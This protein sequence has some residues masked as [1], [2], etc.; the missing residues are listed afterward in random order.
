MPENQPELQ[1]APQDTQEAPMKTVSSHEIKSQ[2]FSIVEDQIL[3]HG[4]IRPYSYV[5][6]KQG[7]CILPFY[8]GK[9]ALSREYRY[10]I[11]SYQWQLP[12]GIIDPGETPLVAG[13]RELREETGLIAT[14][15]DMIDLG[16]FYP[17]YGST[18]EQIYLF[19][20]HVREQVN[21]EQEV[22]EVMDLYFK[23]EDEI[24]QMIAHNEFCHAAGLAALLKYWTKRQLGEL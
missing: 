17:S 1:V 4:Q 10:P 13:M 15:E 8:Q 6:I 24:R 5:K 14:A 22:S 16:W 23:S 20:A 21:P 9:I 11:S 7:V 2:R 3:V 12:G 19:A 18:N